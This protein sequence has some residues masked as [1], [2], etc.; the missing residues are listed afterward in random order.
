VIRYVPGCPRVFGT[1]SQILEVDI[2]LQVV[3]VGQLPL[4]LSFPS[5]VAISGLS[6]SE[7]YRQVGRGKLRRKKVGRSAL[8]DTES[9]VDLV[10]SLPEG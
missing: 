4:L 3:D 2:V 8:I 6:R 5:A 9:L 7:L 10:K 1:G